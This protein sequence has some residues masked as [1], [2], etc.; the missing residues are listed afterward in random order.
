VRIGTEIDHTK[1]K[2]TVIGANSYIRVRR[3]IPTSKSDY[4][5]A[6]K[7]IFDLVS[8]IEQEIGGSRPHGFSIPGTT[9]RASGLVR[10][11]YNS[12]FSDH[13]LDRDLAARFGQPVRLMNDANCFALSEAKGGAS[14]GC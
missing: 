3:R 10:N 7:A 1:I 4:A 8:S 13:P 5:G 6:I 11:A 2:S 12:P 14:A 9:S